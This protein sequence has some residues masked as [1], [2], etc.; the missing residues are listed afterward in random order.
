MR[1]S[2]II[3]SVLLAFCIFTPWSL[4]S[5]AAEPIPGIGPA[6]EVQ[7][8]HTNFKFTEGPASDG[9]GNLYFSNIP[10]ATIH[11]LDASG[12]LS[13]F[14]DKSRHAN[15][16]MFN[17]MGELVACEMD[18][19]LAAWNV[20]TKARRVLTDSYKGTRFNAPND[21]VIDRSGGIYFTDPHYSAPR[22]LPQE[23]MCVYY[24]SAKGEVTR[25]LDILTTP[26]GIILSRD[27][28]TLYVFPSEGHVMQAYEVTAPGKLG[29]GRQ[30]CTIKTPAG[31]D[32][33]GCDGVT[34]DVE[35]N[36][37]LTTK[38][39]IQVF[40]PK[41][42]LLGII[43]LPEHPANVTFGGPENKTLY[44]TARTSLYAV[45]MLVKGHR[46]AKGPKAL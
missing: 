41:A 44:A 43:R 27:E 12:K 16:L 11:L 25:L 28:Q 33:S 10:N 22:P 4:P 20:Q 24:R 7:K 8:L 13:V 14:T 21:L 15:G 42:E 30:F 39:G 18:G 35:G 5:L 45:P 29:L 1:L 40:S 6:G 17:N 38:L 26:N 46:F 36:L 34:I 9:Q 31:K 32:L 2:H 3:R 37:Y 23:K 19:Q